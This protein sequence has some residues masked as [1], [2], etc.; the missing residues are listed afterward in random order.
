MGDTTRRQHHS[1]QRGLLTPGPDLTGGCE[2]PGG[3]HTGQG[4]EAG[5][6]PLR[7]WAN[8]C[9]LGGS[10]DPFSGLEVTESD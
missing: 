7:S 10:G 5:W 3:T 1:E 6:E 4:L 8:T 9:L 2:G